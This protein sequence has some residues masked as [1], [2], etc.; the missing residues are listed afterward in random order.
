M[1]GTAN[2]AINAGMRFP[3]PFAR[4]IGSSRVP[5]WVEQAQGSIVSAPIRYKFIPKLTV[6]FSIR[7]GLTA[8]GRNGTLRA[9]MFCQAVPVASH[10]AM[11]AVRGLGIEHETRVLDRAK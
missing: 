11:P 1:G 6:Y 2:G 7:R 9:P 10:A 3:L 8:S 4:C 5:E